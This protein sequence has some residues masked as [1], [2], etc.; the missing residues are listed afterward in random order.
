MTDPLLGC[1]QMMLPKRKKKL[2]PTSLFKKKRLNSARHQLVLVEVLV[3]DKNWDF[4][5]RVCV[6]DV[7]SGLGIFHVARRRDPCV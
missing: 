4:E 3:L 5:I 6:P 2:P 7:G 1:H